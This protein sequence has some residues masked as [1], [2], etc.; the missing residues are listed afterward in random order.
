MPA[1]VAQS[2]LQAHGEPAAQILGI[3]WVLFIG[4]AL[5]FVV[6]MALC[7]VAIAGPAPLRSWL[8][9]R[10]FVVAAGIVFPVL[11]LTALL[12]HTFGIA[13]QMV[14]SQAQPAATRIQVTGELWWWRVRYLDADGH[15]LLETAN[16]I[17]VPVGEPVDLLLASAD[18]V[19]S[20]WLPSLAG[21]LDMLPGHVNR[22]RL[23]ADAAGVYRGQCAEFCGAQHARMALHVVAQPP[24]AHARWLQDARQPAADPQPGPAQRG[25]ALFEQARCSV[26]HTVRGS[27]ANGTLGPDLTHVGSRLT[28]A[29]G[30]LPNGIG[31]LEAWIADPQHAKPGVR[32]PSYRRFS[33]EE[34][35]AL[36]TYLEGLR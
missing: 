19:H 8:S 15:V 31:S 25:R 23:R 35:R 34:L 30:T 11:A 29:A 28:L 4:G 3:T 26:C 27:G 10:R 16:E 1:Q 5:V 24:E 22:L 9:Q 32:M 18:V 7:A 20:V 17:H 2:T 13:A 14:R 36:A 12:V 6:V 33:G 21:K